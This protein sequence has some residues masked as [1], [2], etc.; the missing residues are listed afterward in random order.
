VWDRPKTSGDVAIARQIHAAWLAF[1]MGSL[2]AAAGLPLWPRYTRDARA[3][4]LL[5]TVSQV[6][7]RPHRAELRLWDGVL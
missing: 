4:M 5:D 1:V 3:T 7:E 2:P 6:A